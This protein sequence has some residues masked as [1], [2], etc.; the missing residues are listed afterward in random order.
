MAGELGSVEFAGSGRPPR[1]WLCCAQDLLRTRLTYEA[2]L[3]IGGDK[4]ICKL[5]L[6]SDVCFVFPPRSSPVLLL[7]TY[8][9]VSSEGSGSEE[10]THDRSSQDGALRCGH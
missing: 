7:R 9:Y 2:R 10:A 6:Y 4:G 1:E 5:Q 8:V 3:G